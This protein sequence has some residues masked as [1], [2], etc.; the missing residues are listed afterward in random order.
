MVSNR[1]RFFFFHY[2]SEAVFLRNSEVKCFYYSIHCENF[3][4]ISFVEIRER[5]GSKDVATFEPLRSSSGLA[6]MCTA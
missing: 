3:R 6:G 4:I 5:L 1:A 2:V